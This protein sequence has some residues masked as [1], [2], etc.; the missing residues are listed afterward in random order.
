MAK[1]I[2]LNIDPHPQDQELLSRLNRALPD[3]AAALLSALDLL[4]LLH[5]RGILDL[6]RGATSAGAR[7]T[8][9]LS[10]AADS[11]AS[12]RALR[13][14]IL[15]GKM[16]SSIDPATMSHIVAAVNETVGPNQPPQSEPPR[17]IT[18]FGHFKHKYVRRSLA[19]CVRFFAALGRQLTPQTS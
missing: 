9:H 13:N 17:L 18:L 8:E 4:Q 12:I 3:H 1:P 7:L 5:D 6:L 19:L 15:M 11:E 16:I 2:P 10:S 14:L